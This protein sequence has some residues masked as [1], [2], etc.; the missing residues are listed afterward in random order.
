MAT[1]DKFNDTCLLIRVFHVMWWSMRFVHLLSYV[2]THHLS[3]INQDLTLDCKD[4]YCTA[5][6]KKYLNFFYLFLALML[7]L[8]RSTKNEVN[9]N[10]W[11]KRF[12]QNI[13][14]VI[15]LSLM[16]P[17]FFARRHEIIKKSFINNHQK[18]WKFICKIFSK[19]CLFN[20]IKNVGETY[21]Q[22]RCLAFIR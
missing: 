5:L 13:P 7:N 22:D 15:N 2:H 11:G 1:H 16:Y 21:D 19:N 18:S 3:V 4:F 9:S 17:V 10:N 12:C 6:E 14:I 20:F 8:A